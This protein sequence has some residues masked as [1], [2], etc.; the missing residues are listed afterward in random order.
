MELDKDQK[1]IYGL[2]SEERLEAFFPSFRSQLHVYKVEDLLHVTRNDLFRIGVLSGP[3]IRRFEKVIGKVTKNAGLKGIFTKV[4]PKKQKQGIEIPAT[5][6]LW[7]QFEPVIIKTE[8]LKLQEVL[9]SGNFGEVYKGQWMR[10]IGGQE[11]TVTEYAEGGSLLEKLQT[12]QILL[13]SLLCQFA[14]QIAS[15]MMYLEQK[16][17][18]HRDL[19]ARNILVTA[20]NQVK[21][22]DF[23]LAKLVGQENQWVMTAPEALPIR[24]VAPESLLEG[25][26][27]S[28]SD[29]WSFGVVLW[30]MFTFGEFPWSE[31]SSKEVIEKI[32]NGERLQEPD[33]CPSNI[34]TLVM[35][36]CW[37]ENP[38]ERMKFEQARSCLVNIHPTSSFA[39]SYRKELGKLHY[40]VGDIIIAIKPYQG[41][42][43]LWVGQNERT[44]EF[45]TY[46]KSETQPHLTK[47]PAAS[48]SHLSPDNGNPATISTTSS[49]TYCVQ[50]QKRSQPIAVPNEDNHARHQKQSRPVSFDSSP[51]SRSPPSRRPPSMSPPSCSPPSRSPLFVCDESTPTDRPPLPPKRED[52]KMPVDDIFLNKDYLSSDTEASLQNEESLYSTID[53]LKREVDGG[54]NLDS[55]GQ[56]RPVPSADKLASGTVQRY[57]SMYVKM[58]EGEQN[59]SDKQTHPNRKHS[60]TAVD[61]APQLPSRRMPFDGSKP[62]A[63]PP[64]KISSSIPTESSKPTD[65]NGEKPGPLMSKSEAPTP[66][67]LLESTQR[68]ILISQNENQQVMQA[69]KQ[70]EAK[71]TR[72][73]NA[74]GSSLKDLETEF[75]NL[76]VREKAKKPRKPPRTS[77][78]FYFD[79]CSLQETSPDYENN[80]VFQLD[81]SAWSNSASNRQ[82]DIVVRSRPLPA[83]GDSESD[84]IGYA[85]VAP[86]EGVL[87][88]LHVP[89]KKYG[90]AERMKKLR[91]TQSLESVC[92]EQNEG[93]PN[94]SNQAE[95]A[96]S[97]TNYLDAG[98][99]NSS[100]DSDSSE[101]D[102]MFGSSLDS[103]GYQK[104][105]SESKG[106]AKRRTI[107]G[108]K[109]RR[110]SKKDR[111]STERR[112]S[113]IE[114]LAQLITQVIE[115]MP[116][117]SQADAASALE[118]SRF[119]V[120]DAVKFLKVK[121][122]VKLELCPQSTCLDMLKT[123]DWNVQEASYAIKIHYIMAIYLDLSMEMAAKLLREN[124]W[125]IAFV[126]NLLRIPMYLEESKE[127]GF[128]E[129][130]ATKMLASCRNDI[131][132]ALCS[133]KVKMVADITQ[134]PQEYCRKTL[135]HCQWKVDRA[136]NFIVE[137][138]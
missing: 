51:S 75:D 11:N 119:N 5:V 118:I 137:S 100:I 48:P 39:V 46:I 15:G 123:Y 86:S 30:E 96:R 115:E 127:I 18:V 125:N 94:A 78:T 63:L 47:I 36:R 65:H 102:G 113:S 9:G 87:L 41:S 58:H 79:D 136:V 8:D 120:E 133:L 72:A 20:H 99:F 12:G 106:V 77:K 70:K 32:K 121:E 64:R 98:F 44:L 53:E 132:M 22:S 88:K 43:D 90:S 34:Y 19:A 104:L 55:N 37:A 138:G 71:N 56:P 85:G 17:L 54:Q 114:N 105:D 60:N 117:A 59:T 67:K 110:R 81:P 1:I 27:T 83:N 93:C 101:G 61:T 25:K 69:I 3:D 62:P 38:E 95:R 76:A 28:A 45:G 131:D 49:V 122:L 31:F 82:E 89:K 26:F 6:S 97:K 23:G 21:I 135:G 24:W 40:S 92:V 10:H 7:E 124:G 42:S 50:K 126:L 112:K 2:L 4:L 35:K 16:G 52:R 129:N 29:V 73:R 66:D 108:I 130:E 14:V 91:K 116:L 68:K 128:T 111:D 80:L 107:F 134:K 33:Y 57:P 13:I 84:R 74:S 103:I 109:L